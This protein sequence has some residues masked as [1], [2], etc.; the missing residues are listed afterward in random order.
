MATVHPLPRSLHNCDSK[1]KRPVFHQVNRVDWPHAKG[2]LD[3]ASMTHET[4][5][6]WLH[7]SLAAAWR[8]CTPR[9][10]GGQVPP[11]P[12]ARALASAITADC[13][14]ASAILTTGG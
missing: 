9:G 6:H 4:Q 14:R 11:L 2:L 3:S 10:R 13:V 8:P 5:A 12:M 1:S 7:R